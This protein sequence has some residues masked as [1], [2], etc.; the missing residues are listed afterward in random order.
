MISTGVGKSRFPVV[1]MEK[2][3]H[4]MIITVA[5]LTQKSATMA[6]CTQEQSCK[7]S[8]CLPLLF[9]YSY[10]LLAILKHTLAYSQLKT[11][12]CQPLCVIKPK[13]SLDFLKLNRVFSLW[14][15]NVT[16]YFKNRLF[17]LFHKWHKSSHLKDRSL[18]N[19]KN[20]KQC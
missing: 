18:L 3:M 4:V 12:F 15:R 7:H 1:C 19:F 5:L 9:T 20:G 10:S 8:N 13:F 16:I 11:Y 6:K 14:F 17:T 2:E